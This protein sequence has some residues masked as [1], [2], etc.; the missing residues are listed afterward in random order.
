M[1]RLSTCLGGSKGERFG[2]MM[3]AVALSVV[4]YQA[5]MSLAGASGSNTF[6]YSIYTPQSHGARAV[7]RRSDQERRTSASSTR[8][9]AT[10][11]S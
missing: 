4:S 9:P 3:A 5:G 8:R 10:S 11:P 1:R 7:H 6:Y 2:Q